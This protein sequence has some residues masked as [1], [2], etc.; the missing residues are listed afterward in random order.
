[1]EVAHPC[2]GVT[3]FPRN[4]RATLTGSQK[5]TRRCTGLA[6]AQP[7]TPKQEEATPH[8]AG[9]KVQSAECA[10]S[11]ARAVM[12]LGKVSCSAHKP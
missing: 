11:G 4:S 8:L 6:R 12:V 10:G 9:C 5:P 7:H 2:V 1:M 3:A